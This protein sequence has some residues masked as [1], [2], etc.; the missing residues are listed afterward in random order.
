MFGNG[1]DKKT[2]NSKKHGIINSAQTA[3]RQGYEA[4]VIQRAMQ[5]GGKNINLKGHINEVRMVDKINFKPSNI[6]KGNKACLTKSTNAVRD[7]IVVKHGG[8]I[9]KR[10]QLK[11]TISDSG[12]AKT[13]KQILSGKYR[14]TN[15]LGTE[16]TVAKVMAKKG[17]DKSKQ[18]IKSNGL[19]SAENER[20][21]AKVLGSTGLKQTAKLAAV[22][23]GK[24]AASSAAIGATVETV[25]SARKVIKG[26]KNV[27][28]AAYS[29]TKETAIAT[30]TGVASKVAGDLVGIGVS[31]LF[32]DPSGMTG[33]AVVKV[34]GTVAGMVS[35]LVTD[36]VARKAIGAAEQKVERNKNK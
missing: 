4:S 29:I 23:T 35:S 10:Y 32:K 15:V 12:A 31:T 19:R 24:V 9:I 20:I 16:E 36:A 33:K 27:K 7:D 6:I 26:E 13:A 18:V 34:G 1:K 11:D 30:G 8:K 25:S 21:A 17:M 22:G 3:A 28:Q 14:G 2:G 5:R